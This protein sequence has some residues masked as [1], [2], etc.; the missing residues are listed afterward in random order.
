MSE[1]RRAGSAMNSELCDHAEALRRAGQLYDALALLGRTDRPDP[2]PDL[3]ASG[4]PPGD[5]LRLA[6]LRGAILADLVFHANRGY[7]EAVA[8]LDA[9]RALA[10]RCG[11]GVSTA[12]ALDLVGMADYYR[13]MQAGSGSYEAPMGRFRAA[14]TRREALGDSRGVAESLFHV[15]L[16]LERQ[17][18]YDQALDNY[19]RAYTLAKERGHL[20]ELSYAARHLGYGAEAARDRDAAL[21]Y[22]EESLT[23]RQEL[24]YALL[25]PLAHIALG[26]VLLACKDMDGAA[27]HFERA[28][29]LAE[30]MQ[31]PLARA[32]SLLAL[33][34]TA[35]AR[36]DADAALSSTE[37]ALTLAKEADVPIAIRAA[38]ATR[39]ELAKGRA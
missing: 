35:Q 10:D 34:R 18:E 7:D 38:S 20:L 31:S 36:G 39:D 13:V 19:R 11:D 21:A 23:L 22:F 24:G 29:I 5:V 2:D 4:A 6:L 12:T 16:A 14:L 15:G 3:D 30:G 33:S 28:W 25:L 27:G 8:T 17:E 32:S 9:A 26:D 1:G 37:R